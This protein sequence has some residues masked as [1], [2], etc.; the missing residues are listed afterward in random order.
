M[1]REIHYLYEI[2]LML[3]EKKEI[4]VPIYSRKAKAFQIV[5]KYSVC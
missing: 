5:Q 3:L 1:D 2:L 4:K